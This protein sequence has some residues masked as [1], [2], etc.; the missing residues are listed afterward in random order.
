MLSTGFR[1]TESRT[2]HVEGDYPYSGLIQKAD[3][4]VATRNLAITLAD[5]HTTEA[6]SE[7]QELVPDRDLTVTHTNICKHRGT[8]DSRIPLNFAIF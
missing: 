3:S 5:K 6:R 1:W 2:L 4:A 7:P 8:P